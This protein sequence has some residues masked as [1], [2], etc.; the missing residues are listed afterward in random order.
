MDNERTEFPGNTNVWRRTPEN[1]SNAFNRVNDPI[2]KIIAFNHGMFSERDIRK[3]RL[4]NEK[5]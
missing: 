3:T 2:A 5:C 1:L 4:R